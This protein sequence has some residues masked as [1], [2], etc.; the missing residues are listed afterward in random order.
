MARMVVRN[1]GKFQHLE[2]YQPTMYNL[3]ISDFLRYMTDLRSGHFRDLGMKMTFKSKG[4]F[5]YL[6]WLLIRSV[7]FVPIHA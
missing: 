7:M 4:K 6:K 1:I 3:Y 2:Y 5:K